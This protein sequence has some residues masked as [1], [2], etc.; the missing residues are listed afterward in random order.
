M[1]VKEI[2]LPCHYVTELESNGGLKQGSLPG[3]LLFSDC[4]LGLRCR[5][6]CCDVLNCFF[7]ASSTLFCYVSAY[8]YGRFQ[9]NFGPVACMSTRSLSSCL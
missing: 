9:M 3:C 4:F 2:V 1:E 6:F 8:L 7:L 5:I